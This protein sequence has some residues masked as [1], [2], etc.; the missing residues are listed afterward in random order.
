MRCRMMN[1]NIVLTHVLRGLQ[2]DI[3]SAFFRLP[4]FN[5]I[6]NIVR[7][8]IYLY[9][10]R[11]V[12]VYVYSPAIQYSIVGLFENSIFYRGAF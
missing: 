12:N 9:D 1:G 8:F 6:I 2:P 3:L 4:A 10:S 5:E 7:Y 11:C